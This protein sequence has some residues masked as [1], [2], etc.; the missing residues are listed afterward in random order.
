MAAEEKNFVH[1]ESWPKEPALLKHQFEC[2]T[3][4]PVRIIFEKDPAHVV[5][6][7]D[8]GRPLDVNMAMNLSAK[9][10]IPVCIKLCEPV[11][12][13]SEYNIGIVIF[14]RPVATITVKGTTRFFNCREEM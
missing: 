14:D 3:P 4:C 13:N 7:T 1:I 12:A 9:D 5:V 11:C 6:M 10:T 8:P 2:E